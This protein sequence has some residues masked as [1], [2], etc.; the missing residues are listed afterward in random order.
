VL[1][2]SQNCEV[3]AFTHFYSPGR[4][5]WGEQKLL[6]MS[7]CGVNEVNKKAFAYYFI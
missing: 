4:I 3:K 5:A 7:N 2:R 6:L 1:L